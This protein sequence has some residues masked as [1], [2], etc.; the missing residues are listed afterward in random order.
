[1]AAQP[2]SKKRTNHRRVW[3]AQPPCTTRC[4]SPIAF[5][6]RGPTAR[7]GVERRT[8][9][10]CPAIWPS[11]R[12]RSPR[13]LARIRPGRMAVSP[14]IQPRVPQ[15]CEIIVQGDHF[16][17]MVQRPV[18]LYAQR[19]LRSFPLP[20]GPPTRE[21]TMAQRGRWG[22]F[23]TSSTAPIAPHRDSP[24]SPPIPVRQ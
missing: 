9:V 19:V 13:L 1:V 12:Q 4:Q 5:P 22:D 16:P 21:A 14:S 3:S 17:E 18:L 7:A 23:E 2:L 11:G 24:T 6:A 10:L 15:G 8:V 20:A